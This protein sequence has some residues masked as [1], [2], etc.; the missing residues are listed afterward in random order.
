[1]SKRTMPQDFDDRRK[2]ALEANIEVQEMARGAIE[3]LI[4]RGEQD[5]GA[6]VGMLRR[7]HFLSDVVFSCISPQQEDGTMPAE[8]LE[9][10]RR[11]FNGMLA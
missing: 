9:S 1:M 6:Y 4:A 3:L 5:S 11:Q 8:E 2:L 10:V 7:I